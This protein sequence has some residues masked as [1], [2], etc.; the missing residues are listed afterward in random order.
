MLL[1]FLIPVVLC[2]NLEI[3][4]SSLDE[5]AIGLP[6]EETGLK[7]DGWS[8]E[9]GLNPEELGEYAEGDI[10][11]SPSLAR[12]GLYAH[13]SHWTNGIIPFEIKGSFS[14]YN[15]L[16]NFCIRKF[17]FTLYSLSLNCNK[18]QCYTI[19]SIFQMHSKCK[20]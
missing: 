19:F 15:K 10:L 1:L 7:V 17:L 8:P 13:S 16:N 12:N 9:S 11:F 3:D 5:R 20:I 6:S 4:L 2:R 14:M 18:N